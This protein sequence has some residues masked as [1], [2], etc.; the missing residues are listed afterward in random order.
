MPII[1]QIEYR[2]VPSG[3][4]ERTYHEM[5]LSMRNAGQGALM[6]DLT[7]VELSLLR[8]YSGITHLTIRGGGKKWRLEGLPQSI[9]DLCLLEV[10]VDTLASLQSLTDLR[11]FDY[12]LGNI[13]QTEGLEKCTTLQVL[14]FLRVAGLNDL[15][16]L[17]GLKK[18]EWI[19]ISECMNVKRFPDL[20][21]LDSLRRVII[22][23]CQGLRDVSAFTSAPNLE[24]LIILEAESLR[25]SDFESIAANENPKHVLPGIGKLG[26][27]DFI[28]ASRIL[29][30]R[31][32][33]SYYGGNNE[34]FE[35]RHRRGEH[36]F[37]LK[38]S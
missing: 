2:T 33:S 4:S 22:E 9:Q 38:M 1:R 14:H 26:S 3:K 30:S 23:R 27:Y 5:A 28:E 34:F 36:E 7:R 13:H 20:K 11:V 21:S 16:F 18:L 24:D 31:A 35:V 10:E 17:P 8:F 29:T 15:E 25:F 37:S 19:K 6:M 32:L 12:R